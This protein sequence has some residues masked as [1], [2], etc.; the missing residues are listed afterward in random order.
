ML[1]SYLFAFSLGF[2]P[3]VT[4][5][6]SI[7][8]V[9]QDA[10]A[11][12]G[13]RLGAASGQSVAEL[14]ES[15]VRLVASAGEEGAASLS[16]ALD[17]RLAQAEG[18][19]PKAQ[20][21]L[22]CARLQ[23]D[24][25][26]H[27]SVAKRLVHLLGTEDEEVARGAAALLQDTSFRE[28]K[29][30]EQNELVEALTAAAGNGDRAPGLRLETAV[31]LHVQ[32]GADGQR[33]ARK[34]M[35]DF[36]A[37]SDDGLRAQAALVLARV[38]DVETPRQELEKLARLPTD[39]GALA[40]AY[41]KQE[42]LR[43]LN[44]SRLRKLL[45]ERQDDIGTDKI[46][47]QDD[48]YRIERMIQLIEKASLEG[49]KHERDELI[50]AALDGMLRSLDEH[51]SYLTPK[52]YQR[53]EQDLLSAEY[54]GIGAYVGEDP[55]D[56]LFTITRPIYSGPAYKAGLHS[57]DK[58][59]RIDDWPTL[60]PDGSKPTDEIIKRLKGKP[61]T[62]VKIYV[63]RRGMDPALIDRPT[64]DMAVTITRERIEIPPVSGQ[65]LPGG[66]A[67]VQLDT[68]S[69][70]ASKLL[71]QKLGEFKQQGMKAVILDLR[72]NSGGLL[73]EA[74]RVSNLFLPE[75][76]LIVTTE[77]RVGDPEKNY[78]EK[79]P[80]VAMDM[81]I[82]VLVNR[83][84]ASASEIVSGALQDWKR[85]EIVG[86]RSFGKGSVQQLLPIPGESDDRFEDEN[87]N[88]RHDSW[89]KLTADRNKNG[90]F[91]YGPRA[92]MTIARYLLPSGRSIHREL[93]EEGKL[94]SEGGVEPDEKVAP[95]RWETWKLEE[96]LKLQQQKDRK[97]PRYV[98][99]IYPA[100]KEL[101]NRLADCDLD[102]PSA[103]PGFDDFYNSLGTVLSP[104]DV[105]FLVRR[106][107]RRKAQDDRGAAFPDGDY[108]EDPQLQEAIR[109]VLN[110]LG[111]GPDA[112]PQYA[113]TFESVDKDREKDAPSR[114]LA[115]NVSDAARTDLRESLTL[116]KNG[117][118]L[119]AHQMEELEKL[120]K[121]V[122]DK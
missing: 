53:F 113:K 58:I 15:A 50:D 34:E 51:S 117:K 66:V 55:D 35:M 39:Q 62:P 98:E 43:R 54:G 75:G 46:K 19:A 20:L 81:P 31:A 7:P 21:F 86:Q 91:D 25:F 38:G 82:A 57:D 56:H 72:N 44:D 40:A 88:G 111:T 99:S 36:L 13:E 64:E 77:S 119:T 121:S 24:E 45:R 26:D 61:G 102:D 71:Q 59:V 10:N 48:L 92:R 101:M 94:L 16:R 80:T 112:I 118:P 103:Y 114:I 2:A 70:V 32:G 74:V 90:E 29:D 120:L 18:L 27:A 30:K 42:E 6:S 28:L 100:N 107:V 37:S 108:Q 11:L 65:M 78:T 5:P 17:E 87:G 33:A 41:L 105:R 84:S 49:D 47:A 1:S 52:G 73:S 109:V 79:K 3:A 95:R 97:I 69:N 63:W 93:D 96:M 12:L 85:G 115:S 14:L 68:F 122:L 23:D 8:A 89:E 22:C 106:E 4:A 76:K 9:H 110:G 116:I 67:L 83:F 104:Q 60:G